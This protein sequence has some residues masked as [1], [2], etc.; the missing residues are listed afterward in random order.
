MKKEICTNNFGRFFPEYAGK[1]GTP[2]LKKK[3]P[4]YIPTKWIGFHEVNSFK[5]DCTQT[6]VHFFLDDYH[7]ERVWKSPTRYLRMLRQFAL[8]ATPDYS[9]YMGYPFGTIQV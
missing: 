8:V 9:M 1:N 6:G 2:L 5:G 7:F 4:N 3:I